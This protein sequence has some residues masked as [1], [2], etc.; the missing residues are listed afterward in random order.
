MEEFQGQ[1]RMVMLVSTV[2]SSP[3]YADHDQRF[4]LGFVKNEKVCSLT[5]KTKINTG[6]QPMADRF[7]R[8]SG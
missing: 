4:D 5:D 1:E 6:R 2:R 7:H 8:S 3:K